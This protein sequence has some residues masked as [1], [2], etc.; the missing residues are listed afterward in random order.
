MR[1]NAIQQGGVCLDQ[2]YIEDV[3]EFTYLGSVM[4]KSGG[5]DE[6]ITTRR[7][8]AKQTFSML[9]PVCKD[10]RTATKIRVFNTNVKA[11]LLYGS[12]T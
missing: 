6:D 4:S 10:L 1:N 7:K 5:T 3:E 11:V 12:E 9:S 2:T 8:K